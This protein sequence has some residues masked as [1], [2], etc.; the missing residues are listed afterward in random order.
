MMSSAPVVKRF[1]SNSE[2]ELEKIITD[3]NNS[4]ENLEL[5]KKNVDKN[6]QKADRSLN[7]ELHLVIIKI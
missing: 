5:T 1:N 3:R 6:L 7:T 4:T 2:E